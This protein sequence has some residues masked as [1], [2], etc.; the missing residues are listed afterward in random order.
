MELT[1]KIPT[2]SRGWGFMK[3]YEEKA[4]GKPNYIFA[5]DNDDLTCANPPTYG[6]HFKGDKVSKI[7]AV[8]RGLNET[9][10]DILLMGSDDMIPIEMGFDLIIIKAWKDNFED[11]TNGL[12][13]LNDSEQKRIVTCGVIGRDYFNK[14]GYYYHPSYKSLWSDNEQTDVALRDGV[15]KKF[16][17]RLIEHR[18]PANIKGVVYDNLYKENDK[19]WKEDNANY[20][21]RKALN[22]PK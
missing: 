15:L 5:Y 1:I 18:H 9:E 10:W 3:A 20:I 13:W 7:E 2:R 21:K 12:L 16:D 19:Y 11:S 8:N 4:V 14:Y 22:F 17:F 6:H